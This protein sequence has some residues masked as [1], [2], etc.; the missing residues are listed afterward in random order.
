MSMSRRNFIGGGLA[1]P[2]I[3][4]VEQIKRIGDESLG[5]VPQREVVRRNEQVRRFDADSHRTQRLIMFKTLELHCPNVPA[6]TSTGFLHMILSGS[7]TVTSINSAIR[8][9]GQARVV[10]LGMLSNAPITAGTCTPQL[11]VA[12]PDTTTYSFAECEL[13]SAHQVNDLVLSWEQAP[14]IAKDATWALN[15]ITDAAFLPTTA[16]IKAWITFGF[17]QW[18]PS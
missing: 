3:D 9:G 8:I 11:V 1:A 2:L 5:V 12:E 16:D 15:A 17:E 18:L 4:P 7:T 6:N 13:S 14:Q 10:A